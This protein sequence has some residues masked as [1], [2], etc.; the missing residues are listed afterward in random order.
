MRGYMLSPSFGVRFKN[1][2]ELGR[3]S[4]QRWPTNFR[5]TKV[6]CNYL[7]AGRKIREVKERLG[8][9]RIIRVR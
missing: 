6:A 9:A 1:K 4:G 3:W 2:V 5:G 7:T 8:S